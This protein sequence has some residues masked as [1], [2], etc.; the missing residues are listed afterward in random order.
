MK[1]RLVYS[2]FAEEKKG[3]FANIE[4]TRQVETHV[5]AMIWVRLTHH[6]NVI[7][8]HGEIWAVN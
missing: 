3:T 1:I 5:I 8:T 6:R 7:L 2:Y 4:L